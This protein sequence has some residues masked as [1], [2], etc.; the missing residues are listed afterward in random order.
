[1]PLPKGMSFLTRWDLESRRV[2]EESRSDAGRKRSARAY[3]AM[4]A[5]RPAGTAILS[6]DAPVI[7]ERELELRRGRRRTKVLVRFRQPV[8]NRYGFAC[9]FQIE[10]LLDKPP[11]RN[12]MLGTDGIEA[13]RNAMQLAMVYILSSQAYQR[14][15]LTWCETYDLGLP[16]HEE[17]APLIRRD[18]DASRFARER[19]EPPGKRSASFFEH[20]RKDPEALKDFNAMINEVN[21]ATG[22][23]FAPLAADRSSSRSATPPRQFVEPQ[24]ELRRL[25]PPWYSHQPTKAG[26]AR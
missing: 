16:V 6:A 13:L 22:S 10:G 1:M 5:A 21:L 14:G 9:A 20:V 17:I 25:V 23:K 7:V 24:F 4:L 3:K 19:M 2:A 12:G 26:E 11:S 8:R 15:R 18:L